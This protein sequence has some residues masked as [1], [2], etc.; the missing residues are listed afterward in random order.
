MLEAAEMPDFKTK[1]RT[2][3]DE[4]DDATT[5]V[6]GNRVSRSERQQ[7]RQ[8]FLNGHM[9]PADPADD[10]RSERF[11]RNADWRGD[12]DVPA[13]GEDVAVGYDPQWIAFLEVSRRIR[14]IT[15]DTEDPARPQTG[16]AAENE[17]T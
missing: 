6:K 9:H 12:D 10:V 14:E 11:A 17:L 1:P 16:A 13:K 8:Q 2:R 5:E 3:R 4:A 15:F 7:A